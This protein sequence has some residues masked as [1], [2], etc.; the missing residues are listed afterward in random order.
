MAATTRLPLVAYANNAWFEDD[1]TWLSAAPV[2]PD[3]YGFCALAWVSVGA[4]MLGGC[5]GTG[6][7]HIAALASQLQ[8]RRS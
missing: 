3:R 1:S 2:T 5:C 4:Q 8:R 7:E 6:P